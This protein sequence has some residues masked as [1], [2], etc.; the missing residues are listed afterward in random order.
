MGR[1]HAGL[2]LDSGTRASLPAECLGS[3]EDLSELGRSRGHTGT[4]R[5][6]ISPSRLEKHFGR[7]R[8][9]SQGGPSPPTAR[10]PAEIA[11]RVG[12]PAHINQVGEDGGIREVGRL[13]SLRPH[14]N[15]GR[16]AKTC[17]L[18]I[19]PS[20]NRVPAVDVRAGAEGERALRCAFRRV[21]RKCDL[22]GARTASAH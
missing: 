14:H 1:G 2:T 20:I 3:D 4:A 6:Q 11:T 15:L 19:H 8:R 12:D 9:R 13:P 18:L 5:V 22:A 16:M 17:R 10:I 21:E 7:G